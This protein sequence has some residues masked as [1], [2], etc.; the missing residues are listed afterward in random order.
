MFVHL[1]V[2][3]QYS[4]LDGLPSVKQLFEHAWQLGMEAVAITDYANLS[5]VPEI[6]KEA[7]GHPGVR[8]IIGCELPVSSPEDGHARPV[9]LLA[10][11]LTGYRNLM[12]LVSLAHAGGDASPAVCREVVGWFHEGLVCLSGSTEGEVS[13]AILDG[14]IPRAE[15]TARWYR[16]VFGDDYYLEVMLHRSESSEIRKR[17]ELRDKVYLV[18]DICCPVLFRLGKKLGIKVVATNDVRFIRKEDGGA[19]L[20]LTSLGRST[21]REIAYEQA[22]MKT[23]Q[24]MLALFPGHPEALRNTLEIA[25]KIESF[26]ICRQPDLPVFP[27]TETQRSRVTGWMRTYNDI[28]DAG[29]SE[30][31][32]APRRDESFA[33]MSL[34]CHLAFDGA[35]R[36]YGKALPGKV[37]A[38]LREELKAICAAEQ[39]DLFLIYHDIVT[40][41][42]DNGV[43]VG[44]GRGSSPGS[45]VVYC[46][47]ITAVDPL[48]YG[49]LPERFMNPESTVRPTIHIDIDEEGRG[50]VLEHLVEMYG[51]GCVALETA[52]G[53]LPPGLPGYDDCLKDVICRRGVHACTVVLGG[54]ELTE[55]VPL[56][57]CTTRDGGRRYLQSQYPSGFIPKT[58]ALQLDLIG[59]RTLSAMKECLALVRERRGTRIRIEDIPLGDLA[60][61]ALYRRGAT[62]GVFHFETEGMKRFLRKMKPDRLEDLMMLD[63][64]FR[65]EG[66][67]LLSRLVDLK[68]GGERATTSIPEADAVLAE[69]FGITLYQEQVMTIAQRVAGFS[70][71][72]SDRLRKALCRG[73]RAALDVFREEFLR[74]GIQKGNDKDRLERI[75]DSWA[76][77]GRVIFNKSHAVC[78]ALLSYRTAWLKAHFPRE[79]AEANKK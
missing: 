16:S 25:G 20:L 65:P 63:A 30:E 77:L 12:N 57:V 34:L 4:L 52:F 70:P 68:Q 49:L 60:T 73:D 26:D 15:E 47:G 37:R 33:S 58:G 66:L 27:L 11:N 54:R 69:T 13:Q 55:Y 43:L 41:A 7:A 5:A 44:P 39:Q 8:P 21:K 35:R 51:D 2:H 36:R 61:F 31:D 1:H 23:G 24:E 28:I 50:R 72:H 22:Y 3:T 75:W 19:Y 45:L 17:P 18:E 6:I 74:G 42:R 38:G 62:D 53:V 9:V 64:L 10:K 48:R 76:P 59:L 40:W 14:D 29:G 79:F 46:L 56:S 32:G 78:Y 71:G 67:G